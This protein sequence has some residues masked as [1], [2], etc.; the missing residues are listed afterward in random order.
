MVEQELLLLQ[1]EF[2]NA[3]QVFSSVQT[4]RVSWYL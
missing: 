1:K 4:F 2:E 3:S